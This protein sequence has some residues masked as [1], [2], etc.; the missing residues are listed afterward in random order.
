MVV[1]IL[2]IKINIFISYYTI[3][4]GV[5]SLRVLLAREKDDD[6]PKL[7]SLLCETLVAVYI[8]LLVNALAMYDTHML[9]RLVAHRFEQ[10][11]WSALFGGGVKTVLKVANQ[12]TPPRKYVRINC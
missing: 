8:S 2:V 4:L 12:N 7:N 1:Y 10:N 3:T 6:A 5:T 11:M 9:Y